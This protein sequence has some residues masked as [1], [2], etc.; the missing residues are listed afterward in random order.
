MK[1]RTLGLA[2][3]VM[4][5]GALVVGSAGAVLA[6]GRG[7]GTMMGGLAQGYG[8][9]AGYGCGYGPGSMMGG[10]YGSGPGSSN[11]YGF[12]PGGMMGWFG[13]GS[14]NGN[15][16]SLNQA[17]KDVQSYIDRTGNKDLVIDEV[18]EFQDN[19]YA[20]VKE[21]STGIGAFEVLVNKYNGAVIPEPGPNHMWNTKY[22]IMGSNS[23]MGQAMGYQQP[24]GPMTITAAQATKIAQQWLD[25]NQPGS[26]TEKPDQFYGYYTVH[27]LK[28]GKVTGMLSVNG[29]T[30]QVWYHT[31]HGAF[32]QM[33]DLLGNN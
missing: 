1:R 11:G 28:D 6:F 18:M 31:W 9:G 25:Q 27:T 21:K 14:T 22:G 3:A 13:Q 30:G 29:Y 12:G 19:F 2:A 7:P 8:P 5:V 10:N 15:P 23:W 4:L 16:I 24:T 20:I 26:T 33:K 17:Q 32:I